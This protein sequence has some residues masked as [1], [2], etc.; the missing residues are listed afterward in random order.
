MIWPVTNF[1]RGMAYILRR[2]RESARRPSIAGHAGNPGDNESGYATLTAILPF[3]RCSEP[4]F[5]SRALPW[6]NP[7]K[8]ASRSS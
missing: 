5:T 6:R 7:L 8:L 2:N 3:S 1:D 4:A